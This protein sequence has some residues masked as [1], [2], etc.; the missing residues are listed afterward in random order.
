MQ[1]QQQEVGMNFTLACLEARQTVGL[2]Q[3]EL[4]LFPTVGVSA[5]AFPKPC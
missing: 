1:Q 3:E 4:Y 5:R 2:L